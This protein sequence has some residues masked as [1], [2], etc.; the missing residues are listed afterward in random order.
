MREFDSVVEGLLRAT[1]ASRTTLRLDTPGQDFPVVAEARA[2][3]VA[4]IAGETSISQRGAATAQRLFETRRPLIQKDCAQADPPPPKELLSVYGVQAQM[5]G[6][7]LQGGRV[8]GWLSV[9]YAPSPREWAEDD[10]AALERAVARV[11]RALGDR[12]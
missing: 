9:H 1:G 2:E 5:L 4:S 11:E 3:G 6:P 8:I 12:G 7:I 10:V